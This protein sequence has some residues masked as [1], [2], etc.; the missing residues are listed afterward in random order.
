MHPIPYNSFSKKS[1]L[2]DRSLGEK[3][4]RRSVE[5]FGGFG[6][7]HVM[8]YMLNDVFSFSTK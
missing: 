8:L 1:V 3:L 4:G 7:V 2:R 6:Y 5:Y